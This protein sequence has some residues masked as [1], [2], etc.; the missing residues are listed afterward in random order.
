MF[1]IF[2]LL[3]LGYPS[4]GSDLLSEETVRYFI[5]PLL[6][7]LA[8]CSEKTE[9]S[10]KDEFEQIVS[11]YMLKHDYVG[12]SIAAIKDGDVV[13]DRAYG[14]ADQ[15]RKEK[16]SAK[17]V[18]SLGSNTKT[19]TASAILLL[20]E[21]GLLNLSDPLEK[22]LPFK[23]QHSEKITLQEM[24][25]HSS[26]L[27]DVFGVGRFEDYVWQKAKSQKEFIDKLN[28]DSHEPMAG[29]RYRYNNTAYFLLGL[30]VEHVSHQSLGDFFRE[31]IFANMPEANLYYLGDSFYSPI[32]APSFEKNGFKANLYESP[33]EYRVVGGAG[34][35]AG[36]LVSYLRM[37]KS[38][39]SGEILSRDS[40]AMLQSVCRF[41]DGSE[42]INEKKQNIGLGIEVFKINGETV[43]SRG[44]ALNGYVS[45]VYYF[46]S[47]KLTIGVT[48][49]TW[50][51]LAPMLESLFETNWHNEL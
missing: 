47:R 35:L 34:A 21:R 12:L 8:S 36:D 42:V 33:V 31:Y 19:L 26:D 18:I 1:P 27:S 41:K 15:N 46:P 16:F 45:A 49:N 7:L 44:G 51:P 13:F 28:L 3:I 10:N 50:A 22:H 9:P 25:C 30:V 4:G 11:S 43:Y 40:S 14:Y 38:L 2:W 24:L 5:V 37:F 6:F 17:K 48:G 39:V 23:L 29:E 32:L 20:Q